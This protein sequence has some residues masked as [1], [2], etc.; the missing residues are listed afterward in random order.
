MQ[1]DISV[2]LFYGCWANH[3]SNAIL[4]DLKTSFPI[5]N[6]QFDF[7][8]FIAFAILFVCYNIARAWFRRFGSSK[9]L[10]QSSSVCWIHIRYGY[11][12]VKNIQSGVINGT[13][14]RLSGMIWRYVSLFIWLLCSEMYSKG[15]NANEQLL[16]SS[17]ISFAAYK[18]IDIV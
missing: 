10:A 3:I 4:Y 1:I 11:R 5:I 2:T 12:A 14:F 17:S 7:R 13:L 9:N 16:L 15:C 6:I 18:R 8:N